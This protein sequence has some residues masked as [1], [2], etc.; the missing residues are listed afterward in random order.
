MKKRNI[1]KIK[2]SSLPA[3]R[4]V[5]DAI[6]LNRFCLLRSCMKI[7]DSEYVN[8]YQLGLLRYHGV[9]YEVME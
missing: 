4:G 2:I 3:G 1:T 7:G 5:P 6:L 9:G 8:N